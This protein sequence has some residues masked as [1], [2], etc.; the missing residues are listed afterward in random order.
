[1]EQKAKNSGIS[2][3]KACGLLTA[4]LLLP[5]C[6]GKDQKEDLQ[7]FIATIEQQPIAKPIAQPQLQLPVKVIYQ[8]ANSKD[9]FQAIQAV[10]ANYTQPPVTR[11]PLSALRLVGTISDGNNSWAAIATPDGKVYRVAR[12]DII[13]NEGGKA[14]TITRSELKITPHNTKNSPQITTL[15]LQKVDP[16]QEK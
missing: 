6:Q 8:A 5:A 3:A 1:M 13:G 4:T 11:F 7:H 10:M 9:P 14:T 15:R 2:W 16:K 12:G